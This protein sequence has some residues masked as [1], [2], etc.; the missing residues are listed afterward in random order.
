MLTRGETVM[1]NSMRGVYTSLAQIRRT[2]FRE[3][4]RLAY[5]SQSGDYGWVDELPYEIIPGDVA[6]YRESVF[7]ERAIVGERIRL[8]MGL[9]LQGVDKPAKLSEGVAEAAKP[10]TY[11][12]PPLI[13]VIK[14]A[15][16]ACEESSYKVSDACQGCLAH[17]CRE[18]CPKGAITFKDKKAYI[19]QE[20]CIKC[21]RCANVCPYGAIQHRERPCAVA[22]GMNAI[23]SDDQGRAQ[24]DYNKCVS[25][26]QCLV[27]CPFGAIADKSQI[28]Q[29][30]QAILAGEEVI[31]EV[32]PAFVGQFG[33]KGNVD[34]LR[35]AFKALGF[36]GMEE[37]ALGADLCAVQEAEDFLEEVPAKIPFMGTSCCPAWSVMAKMEFP[38]HADC[39]SMALTPM[40]L[41]AR[42]IRK[43]HPN[44]KIVFVGPCS[45]KKLEAQRK[46][47]KSE[48]DFVLTFEEMAGMMEAKDI[49]YTK[50][51]GEGSSDFE[52]ASADG[53][54]F[55]V[56]GGV[57]NAVVNAIHREHPDMEVHVTNAE[58]LDE[59]RKMM[60]AAVKGKFDGYLLEGMACPGGCVAGA[61]TLQPINKTA[62]AVKLYSK[63]APIKTA[64]ENAYCELIH[65]LERDA[66]GRRADA[67]VVAESAEALRPAEDAE[68]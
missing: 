53:R 37:V 26:G 6:T 48:V 10:E 45:A 40:T 22:C 23:S 66:D 47:V 11:Y 27:N 7:L 30:I 59:C 43:Q 34:K 65:D 41:T 33:G 3:V 64:P 42:L 28:F 15:C 36:T 46:S 12:Q 44:A 16:N 14:F 20:K 67:D 61:G 56:A 13:N 51:A 52:V 25:C 17:P 35:E 50:L 39:V 38:E 18:I 32:A 19:D 24:I 58:G 21:G 9:P 68:A 8:A 5:E 63:K 54:S 49:D 4:A 29:V 1:S 31:A 60:K 57:A 55:A 2:V 62:G